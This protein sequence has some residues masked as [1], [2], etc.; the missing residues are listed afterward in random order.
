MKTYKN[1]LDSDDVASSRK[2]VSLSAWRPQLPKGLRYPGAERS[3][4]PC[5]IVQ[6]GNRTP[7]VVWFRLLALRALVT[8][9]FFSDRGSTPGKKRGKGVDAG[10]GLSPLNETVVIQATGGPAKGFS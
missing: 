2:T 3:V 10:E 1:R 7:I 6:P 4:R 8:A 9:D 5:V